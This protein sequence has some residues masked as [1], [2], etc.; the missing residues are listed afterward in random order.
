[1]NT[2]KNMLSHE[3]MRRW[4]KVEIKARELYDNT[5]MVTNIPWHEASKEV[6]QRLRRKAA[7]MLG[8]SIGEDWYT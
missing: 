8:I 6:R 1:M 7:K 3:E 2:D 4:W 5:W